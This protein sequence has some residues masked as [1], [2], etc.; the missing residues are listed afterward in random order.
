LAHV[1][2]PG[3]PRHADRN[4]LTLEDTITRMY[5]GYHAVADLEYVGELGLRKHK[6]NVWVDYTFTTEQLKGLSLGLGYRYSSKNIAGSNITDPNNRRA[7]Y[8]DPITWLADAKIAYP[9]PNSWFGAFDRYI[10]GVSL[11]LNVYNIF[12]HDEYIKMRVADD[13][14]T[15]NRAVPVAPRTWRL[16]A[17]FTF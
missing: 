11:Q 13:G 10:K 16:Q 15:W 3:G 14:V 7:F 1:H 12:D 17:R 6:A 8:G 4:D 2:T 5:Q 9:L